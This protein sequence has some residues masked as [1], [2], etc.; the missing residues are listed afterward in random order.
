[1]PS[2]T[3]YNAAPLPG[4]EQKFDMMTAVGADFPTEEGPKTD[5]N[6]KLTSTLDPGATYYYSLKAESDPEGSPARVVGNFTTMVCN[7]VV[8][9]DSVKVW[10]GNGPSATAGFDLMALHAPAGASAT[11]NSQVLLGYTGLPDITPYLPGVQTPISASI[12]INNAP[13]MLTLTA[14]G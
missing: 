12:N 11:G 2:V 7:V 14:R 5:H 4:P 10:H 8:H 13:W 6:L 1:V 9:F 3:I